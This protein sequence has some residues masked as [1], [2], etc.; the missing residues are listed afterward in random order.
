MSVEILIDSGPLVALFN[1]GDRFHAKALSF[2]KGFRDRPITTWPVVAETL[3]L[4]A[5]SVEAQ[6]GFLEWIE[7]GS[8]QIENLDLLDVRYIRNRMLKYSDIPMDLVD[9]SVMAIAERK[10]I[11]AI[12]SIDSYFTIYRTTKGKYLKNMF[13]L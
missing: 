9:A 11:H 2:L 8:L 7:R 10:S 1:K 13:P 12:A 5:G 6:A 4:L 3:Y